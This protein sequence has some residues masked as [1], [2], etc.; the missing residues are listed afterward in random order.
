M[1]TLVQIHYIQI[2]ILELY[3]SKFCFS[4]NIIISIISILFGG[5]VKLHGYTHFGLKD[6]GPAPADATHPHIINGCGNYLLDFKQL[7][8]CSF[9]LQNQGT[10]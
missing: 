5:V 3:F 6:I 9:P 4:E 7:K 1:E 10:W 2:G 8:F